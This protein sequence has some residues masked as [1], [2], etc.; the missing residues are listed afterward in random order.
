MKTLVIG[1]G[2]VMLWVLCGCDTAPAASE[3]KGFSAEMEATVSG[4]TSRA[5]VMAEDNKYR[6][7][8]I[9][10]RRAS[11]TI[12]RYD[13]NI[14]WLLV[15]EDKKYKKMSVEVLKEDLPEFFREGTKISKK[16]IT[17]ETV[18]KVP[19]VKYKA[20]IT[21]LKNRKYSGYLWEAIGLPGFPLKWEDLES[22]LVVVWKNGQVSDLPN[23]LFELPEGYT[24]I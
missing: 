23:S 19:A 9:D 13:E 18:E 16:E 22:G 3:Q 15:P 10:G 7:E 12:V 4:I 2:M 6:L 21:S 20:E 1:I 24:E 8:I 14:L 5:K 17:R 11:I